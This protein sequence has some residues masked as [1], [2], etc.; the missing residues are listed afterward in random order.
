MSTEDYVKK[1]TTTKKTKPLVGVFLLTSVILMTVFKSQLFFINSL[2][3]Q[4]IV[5]INL[6][7]SYGNVN[8]F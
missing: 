3:Y 7:V 4:D 8:Y 6:C 5:Y 1:K 2:K